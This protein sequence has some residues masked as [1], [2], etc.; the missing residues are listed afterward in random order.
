MSKE[1]GREINLTK[2][3]NMPRFGFYLYMLEC[4]TDI[5][6]IG[7]ILDMITDTDFNKE[8][9]GEK[10]DDCGIDAVYI[11]EDEKVINLFNFKYRENYK[12]DKS[13][14]ENDVFIST[15]FSNAIINENSN[16]LE[17]KLRIFA[18]NIIER[19]NSNDIWKMKLKMVTNEGEGLK[20]NSSHVKQ[21]KDLY[22]LD[23]ESI[24]LSEI[25]NYMAIRPEAIESKLILEK[26]S[27]LTY[28][29]NTLESA[30]SYLI[31]IP[32]YEL[33]RITCN[34]FEYRNYYNIEDIA[35]LSDVKLD[36]AVLFDNVRGFLGKTKYNDNINKTLK[37][38]PSKFFMYN[39]GLTI[40]ADD[41]EAKL[42][43]GKSKYLITIKNFQVVNG[44]QT[45]RSIHDFNSMD[46]SNLEQYLTEGE[47]LVKLFKTG[48]SKLTNKISE[49][50][51]SQNAISM[52]NLK[53][54]AAEQI[55]IEQILDNSGIVYARKTGDT[56]ID[57]DKEYRHK[58]SMEKFGQIL[59]SK[60]GNPDKASNQKIKIFEKYYDKTFG[61]DNFDINDAV[62][63]VEDYKKIQKNYEG[64]CY[65]S[66]DQKIFYIIYIKHYIN[67]TVVDI[68]EKFEILL[69]S[70][71][72]GSISPAR[73]LIQ[74]SFKDF[75]DEEFNIA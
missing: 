44:G 14:S 69:E 71:K 52:I 20:D 41:I 49:Y 9:Y 62:S 15:K 3:T 28:T 4:I 30:K 66:T 32:L 10:Y 29:E 57:E 53:A 26:D 17:G 21:L 22:D 60:Q 19:N 2:Q 50:T 18:E 45:L 8:V 1:I 61:E 40:T 68:I 67:E 70:Y 74:K 65:E 39:N 36:Y 47:I 33:V 12:P 35:P 64:S 38:E 24:T 6:D 42:I 43:N 59:F 16:H 11:D 51:N 23:V 55:Q 72:R 58:I 63:I 46:K 56:G 31:K 25:S 34:T 27:I 54:V 73:K 5:R 75:I 37:L 48:S 13:I 7:S